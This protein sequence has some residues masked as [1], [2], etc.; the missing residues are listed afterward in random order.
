MGDGITEA[1]MVTLTASLGTNYQPEL[2]RIKLFRNGLLIAD[3]S[4]TPL[5]YEAHEQGAYRAEV[6]L[7]QRSPFFINRTYTWIYSNP[8]YIRGLPLGTG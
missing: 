6:E 7:L 4:K 1:G 3:S 5:T 8:I 2:Y